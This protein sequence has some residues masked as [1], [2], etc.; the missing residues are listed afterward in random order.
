[1]PAPA[2]PPAPTDRRPVRHDVYRHVRDASV[3]GV[4]APGEPLR[5]GELATWPGV[6]RTPVRE[7]VLRLAEAG[8]VLAC[9][10]RSTTVKSIAADDELRGVPVAGDAKRAA[11]VA[12]HTW[13]S[14]PM[15]EE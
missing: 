4:L 10:S 15:T 9:P 1:M 14:L 3:A 6:G 2:K 8:L 7:A 11:A 13:H 5:D 12:F